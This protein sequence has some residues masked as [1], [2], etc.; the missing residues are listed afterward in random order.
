MTVNYA[1]DVAAEAPR[2]APAGQPNWPEWLAAWEEEIFA[3]VYAALVAGPVAGLSVQAML[4]DGLPA[5][6][7]SDDGDHP[8]GALRPAAYTAALRKLAATRP[9]HAF[10]KRILHAATA[11]DAKLG[12]NRKGWLP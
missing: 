9:N 7:T 12:R 1:V 8:L 3:D 6:L 10:R 5:A 4:M 2:R 11:L